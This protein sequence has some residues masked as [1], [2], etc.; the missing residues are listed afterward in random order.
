MAKQENRE[1]KPQ[2]SLPPAP[3]PSTARASVFNASPAPLVP[4]QDGS[5]GHRHAQ[6]CPQ[7]LNHQ[8]DILSP[9]ALEAVQA[10]LANCQ[11]AVAEGADKPALEKQMEN[12]EKV[13]NKWLKPYPNAAWR[14][15][16]EVLL[17]ALAVAMGIRTFFLQPFKIP[18][19]S[20][21]P[22]LMASPRQNLI[23]DPISRSRRAGHA[24]A[25]GSRAS[26]TST[27]WRKTTARC[28]RLIAR[29]AFSSST[30]S[31]RS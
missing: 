25:N 26:P 18:T 12:L 1:S 8:R 3:A 20:M 15:N 6:P 10:A 2:G 16:V 23:N 13:A 29:S 14:E 5:P 7:V 22:T 17:V 30:S 19:G 27:W 9:Q 28:R 31:K 24:C 21:Q 11:R 4:L